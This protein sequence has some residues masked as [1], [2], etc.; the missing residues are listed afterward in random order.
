MSKQKRDQI[1]EILREVE[2][3]NTDIRASAVVTKDGLLLAS[4]L[5]EGTDGRN[6]SA[7]AAA[8]HSASGRAVKSLTKGDLNEVIANSDKGMVL[9]RSVG[10]GVLM[11]ITKEEPNLGWVRMDM[12]KAA[13]KI[14][15]F[16]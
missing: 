9:C 12:D 3:E 7:M 13:G 2:K 4:A 11:T 10:T 14:A 5:P 1:E 16:L 8:I 6:V 15:E